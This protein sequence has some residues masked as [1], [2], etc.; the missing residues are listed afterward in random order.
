MRHAKSYSTEE[1]SSY[2][3]LIFCRSFFTI[4]FFPFQSLLQHCSFRKTANRF[5]INASKITGI[6]WNTPV[7]SDLIPD[8]DTQT[9][10]RMKKAPDSASAYECSDIW[11]IPYRL[12]IRGPGVETL[13]E[14]TLETEKSKMTFSYI[15]LMV[16]DWNT[17]LA[18]QLFIIFKK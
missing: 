2:L 8:L 14:S 5:S 4:S 17:I 18:F 3:S 12:L 7:F 1:L 11:V 16:F 9:N 6:Y 15:Y 10:C 13:R